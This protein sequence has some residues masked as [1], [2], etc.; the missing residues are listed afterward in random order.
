[1]KINSEIIDFITICYM[2][3]LVR[4]FLKKHHQHF[5]GA[6][7]STI[8]TG[9]NASKR[10]S[11]SYANELMWTGQNKTKMLVWSKTVCCAFFEMTTDTLEFFLDGYSRKRTVL[12]TTA[13]TKP[14]WNSHTTELTLNLQSLGFQIK[15]PEKKP[16]SKV[17]MLQLSNTKEQKTQNQK[18]RPNHQ[19]SI[20]LV[21]NP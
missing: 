14:H 16:V 11:F 8:L 20:T 7:V 1:M 10:N 19:F 15:F 3:Q 9:E 21:L 6:L 17:E 2:L 18:P 5:W 4:R 12:L 13:R